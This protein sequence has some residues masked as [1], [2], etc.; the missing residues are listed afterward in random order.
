MASESSAKPGRQ[1]D[2]ER[3]K[4]SWRCE[5]FPAGNVGR[6]RAIDPPLVTSSGNDV[7]YDVSFF[8]AGELHVQ[9][10]ELDGHTTVIDAKQM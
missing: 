1:T 3:S 6:L 10:L 9:S 7:F 2:S 5:D 4:A 8:D